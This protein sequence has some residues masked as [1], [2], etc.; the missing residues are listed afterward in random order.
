M[1]KTLATFILI[2]ACA[3]VIYNSVSSIIR[4]KKIQKTIK[5][6]EPKKEEDT[7]VKESEK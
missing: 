5:K 4:K 1:L 7:E 3:F 6:V 2:G